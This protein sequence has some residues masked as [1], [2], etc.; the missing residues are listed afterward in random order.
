MGVSSVFWFRWT[1]ITVIARVWKVSLRRFSNSGILNILHFDTPK[2]FCSGLAHLTISYQELAFN[3]LERNL[4]L[5]TYKENQT[6]G[7]ER[8]TQIEIWIY[9]TKILTC[10]KC[11]QNNQIKKLTSKSLLNVFQLNDSFVPFLAYEFL[12]NVQLCYWYQ[13][14]HLHVDSSNF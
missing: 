10:L 3:R 5:L 6:Y 11:A 9:S 2:K 8:M 1:S 13:C 4:N 14:A 7:Q 12:Q